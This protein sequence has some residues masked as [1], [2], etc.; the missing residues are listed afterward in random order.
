MS[1]SSL[2]PGSIKKKKEIIIWGS[3]RVVRKPSRLDL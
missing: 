2:L 3:T 1:D